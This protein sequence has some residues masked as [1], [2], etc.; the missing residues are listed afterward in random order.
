MGCGQAV[1]G[2]AL[3]RP[4]RP[5]LQ[6]RR[7]VGSVGAGPSQ[8][9]SCRGRWSD[10]GGGGGL[11]RRAHA[12]RVVRRPPCRH[13]PPGTSPPGGDPKVRRPDAASRHPHRSRSCV[14]AGGQDRPRTDLRGRLPTLQLR[15][16]PEALGH[17]RPR[18]HPGGVPQR[19][20][21]RLRGR[22]SQLLGGL[23]T[24]RLPLVAARR[25][26]WVGVVLP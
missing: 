5:H 25:K 19:T 12:R 3:P 10:P 15:V 14:P 17:R 7:P 23:N 20:T 24:L 26:G 1:S 8:S 4:L 9:W 16:P 11:R 21:V 6:E 13:L 2:S 18:S 22:H